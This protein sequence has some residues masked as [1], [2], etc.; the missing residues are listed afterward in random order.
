MD[1][2]PCYGPMGPGS[3]RVCGTLVELL[4]G[5][6]GSP[7]L[8]RRGSVEAF[9][10]GCGL[11][12]YPVQPV[13]YPERLTGYV[14]LVLEKPLILAPGDEAAFCLNTVHDV[15]VAPQGGGEPGGPIDVFTVGRAKYALY[16][17]PSRGILA[18]WA[19]GRPGPCGEPP[20]CGMQVRVVAR[21]ASGVPV[22]LRRIVYPA[23]GIPLAYRGCRVLGPRVEVLAATGATARVTAEPPKPPRGWQLAPVPYR[24]GGVASPLPWGEQRLVYTMQY[25]L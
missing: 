20:S 16:G 7:C 10:P 23:S 11:H 25:G 6:E 9:V 17:P 12:V 1:S 14:M 13:F 5:G 21:N 19:P 4:Q 18:R 24:H 8:Y 15:A 3:R 2:G 22:A